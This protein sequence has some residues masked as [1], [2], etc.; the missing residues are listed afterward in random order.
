[1]RKRREEFKGN[2]GVGGRFSISGFKRRDVSETRQN[3]TCMVSDWAAVWTLSVYARRFLDENA[4]NGYI[5]NPNSR[6]ELPNLICYPSMLAYDD[7]CALYALSLI[8]ICLRS[9]SS[10]NTSSTLGP[11]PSDTH[12]QLVLPPHLLLLLLL[13]LMLLLLSASSSP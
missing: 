8:L 7:F 11:T 12:A 13:P 9:K 4:S 5:C 2:Y 10:S 1:L 3:T 6:S